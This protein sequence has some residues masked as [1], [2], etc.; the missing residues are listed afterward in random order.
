MSEY[1]RDGSF[2]ITKAALRTTSRFILNTSAIRLKNRSDSLLSNLIK[3]SRYCLLLLI[4]AYYW[5]VSVLLF[6]TCRRSGY[7]SPTCSRFMFF[8]F[9]HKP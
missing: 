2:D 7:L 1:H 5:A 9:A 6:L 8:N 3:S 4:T